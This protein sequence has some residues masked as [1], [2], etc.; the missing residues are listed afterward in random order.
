M[1]SDRIS[2]DI[3]PQMFFSISGDPYSNAFRPSR[4]KFERCMPRIAA[5]HRTK[6][7]VINDVKIFPTVYRAG[8]TVTNFLTLSTQISRYKIKC[9]RS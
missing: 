1:I 3:P 8:Y 4:L 7:N 9:I 2:D 5:R 6:R